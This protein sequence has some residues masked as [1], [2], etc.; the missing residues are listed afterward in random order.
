M[1]ELFHFPSVFS[2]Y[3]VIVVVVVGMCK[4]G[5]SRRG[6]LEYPRY[7][8]GGFERPPG[9]WVGR[10]LV[11]HSGRGLYVDNYQAFER[12][13]RTRFRAAGQLLSVARIIPNK[14]RLSTRRV[15][16]IHM[17]AVDRSLAIMSC[18]ICGGCGKPW[19]Q[20]AGLDRVG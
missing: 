19:R 18:L 10:Q 15:Q 13:A 6:C 1:D 9:V 2:F 4:Q 20:I 7:M 16:V 3:H 14:R 8:G 12:E 17:M 11:I 5:I